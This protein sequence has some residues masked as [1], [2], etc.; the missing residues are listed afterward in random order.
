MIFSG[1][2]MKLIKTVLF[3][4]LIACITV[5]PAAAQK[6]TPE[7][8]K[9]LKEA[10]ITIVTDLEQLVENRQEVKDRYVRDL[11]KFTIKQL[12]SK[13]LRLAIRTDLHDDIYGGCAFEILGKKGIRKRNPTIAFSP[14]MVNLYKNRPSIVLSAFI[15]EAQHARS[16]FDDQKR[17]LVTDKNIL[18]KYLY[19]LDAYNAE[20][21][22]IR[23][24]LKGNPIYSLTRFE[25]ILVTS[26]NEDYLAYFSHALLG[27]DMKLTFYINDL[28]RTRKSY[29]Q[30]LLLVSNL[31]GDLKKIK[32]KEGKNDWEKYNRIVSVYTAL[33]FLPQAIRDIDHVH[34]KIS[35]NDNYTL[36]KYQPQL[37][38]E[39]LDLE[40]HFKKDWKSY[41]YLRRIRAAY[42]KVD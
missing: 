8:E 1:G 29:R 9:L 16:F 10:Y 14:Y 34:E 20:S 36:K 27:Y 31:I 13:R 35:E 41:E 24:Y 11:V 6:F 39:L 37:L 42:M 12:K 4:F 23:D 28:H 7:K 19:E 2:I 32:V 38:K 33:K 18:E 17:Y 26:F 25:K 30:K 40:K 15:H 21:R 3:S 22:F 5:I